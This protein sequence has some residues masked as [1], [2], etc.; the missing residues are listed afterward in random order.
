MNYDFENNYCE[1]CNH[2]KLDNSLNT[3]TCKLSETTE[4]ARVVCPVYLKSKNY[5]GLVDHLP[6]SDFDTW[7]GKVLLQLLKNCP[8]RDK[9]PHMDKII[10]VQKLN[11]I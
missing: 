8:H 7:T 4:S 10:L 11:K 6:E 9:L 2:K 1:T 3:F 5:P